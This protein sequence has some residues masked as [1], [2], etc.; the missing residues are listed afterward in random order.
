MEKASL[1]AK[2]ANTPPL[3]PNKFL[4]LLLTPSPVKLVSEAPAL[5]PKLVVWAFASDAEPIDRLSKN[6]VFFIV[7]GKKMN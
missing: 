5:R 7:Q 1:I 2:F 4:V 6:K 3:K